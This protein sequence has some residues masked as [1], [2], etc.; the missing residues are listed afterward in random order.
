LKD[1][2]VLPYQQAMQLSSTNRD[3]D[4]SEI[5]AF[6]P[7]DRIAE[8]SFASEHV[9]HDGAI[10]ALMACAASL[11]KARALLEGPWDPCLKWIDDRLSELWRMRGPCPGLGSALVAFG[12]QLGTFVAREVETNLGENEDPWPAVDRMFR[13]PKSVLPA[14]LAT[15]VGATLRATWA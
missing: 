9:S 13:D 12:V 14:P 11:N 10:A 3:F 1:G 8:F 4:P 6:S 7:A 15:Q 5:A 2:F